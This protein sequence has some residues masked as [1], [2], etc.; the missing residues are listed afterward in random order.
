MEKD[1]FP[2]ADAR[3]EFFTALPVIR[4]HGYLLVR[5]DDG[6]LSGI[7][8]AADVTERFEG[9]AR[10]FFVVGEIESLLRRC[11]GAAL[12]QDS[13][14][15]VQTNR[16]AER[17]T[18][19]VSDLMFGDYLKLLDGEQNGTALAARADANWEALKWPNMPREQFVGRLK[20]VKDIRNRI[21][22][23]DEKP[24]PREMLEELTTFANLLR[25]FAS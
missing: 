14:R 10:P 23:F 24:L 12:D 5:G 7:V 22:H 13:I 20:R 4:E 2:L 1:S 16:R 6:C 3:Q 18:G 11:L 8:T 15:A 25:A 21:A 17:R 9:A 19:Q